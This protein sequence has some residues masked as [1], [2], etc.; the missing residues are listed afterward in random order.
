MPGGA[1]MTGMRLARLQTPEGVVASEYDL[2]FEG[3]TPLEL[4]PSLTMHPRQE[5]T[6]HLDPR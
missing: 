6:M 5:M 2:V 1:R 4:L 3:E